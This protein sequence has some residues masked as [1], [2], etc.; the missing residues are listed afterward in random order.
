MAVQ[1]GR[2]S[3]ADSATPGR[4]DAARLRWADVGKGVFIVLV[5][6]H[7]TVN[8]HYDTVVPE[9]WDGLASTWEGAT[10]ALKP[11]RMP[12]FF[13][14]S[15]LFAARAVHR[16]WRDVLRPRIVRP[17]YLYVLWLALLAVFFSYARQLPMNR[18]NSPAEYVEDLLFAS[19]SLWY[20]YATVVYFVAVRLT[21]RV[22]ARAVVALGVLIAT[23]ASVWSIEAYN[24]ESVVIHVVYFAVGARFPELVRRI[25]EWRGTWQVA[26]LVVL[27]VA[28]GAA[29]LAVD[30][31]RGLV[32]LVL[33][34]IAVPVGVRAIVA[35][36]AAWPRVERGTAWI[37]RRTL[38]IYVLHVPVLSLLHYAVTSLDQPLLASPARALP[39]AVLG[40]VALAAYPLAAALLITGVCLAVH[41]VAVRTPLRWLFRLPA[42]SRRRAPML[43][44]E[45]R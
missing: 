14:L 24:R 29:L 19:T 7:H 4:S 36:S 41:A 10:L 38:P 11:L 12:L 26:P 44:A 30:A 42:R 20:L 17:A 25:G 32:T 45:E 15:G 40:F 23:T 28:L 16:P 37:G 22:D 9:T 1:H 8:K 21:H 35:A 33:A 3:A 18:T 6:L 34:A 13:M 31:P 2:Q 39:A 27:Y 43:R 5:V